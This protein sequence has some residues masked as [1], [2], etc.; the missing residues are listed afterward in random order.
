MNNR[1]IA[2]Y[3]NQNSI[4]VVSSY[5][6]EGIKYSGKV[7]AVGGYAKNTLLSLK[8]YFKENNEDRKIVVLTLKT[9]NEEMYIENGILVWRIFERNK[10]LSYSNLLKAILKFNLIKDVLVEFEFASFG[11]SQTTSLLP[12]ILLFLRG[13][14]KNT[15][16]VLHQVLS[17]LSLLTGHLGWKK[18]SIKVSIYNKILQIFLFMLILPVNKVVVL[19]ELLKKRL[20]SM[21]GFKEKIHVIP[22]GIDRGFKS[23][24]KKIARNKLNIKE[25]EFV[26]LYFGYLTW[27]KGVDF[28][29]KTLASQKGTIGG[30]K[31]RLIIAGGESVTQKTKIHYKKFVDYIYTLTNHSPEITITGFVPE[32]S[33]PLYFSA[34][35]LVVLPYRVFMSSSGPLSFAATFN[36]PF[37]ISSSL[38]GYFESSDFINCL[39]ESGLRKEDIMFAL[40]KRKF[41]EKL[42]VTMEPKRLSSL[43]T[44]SQLLAKR[45]DFRFLAPAYA[46]LFYGKRQKLLAPIF[47]PVTLLRSTV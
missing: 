18:T 39:K 36:K 5:P 21:V 37:I 9:G 31:I 30:R 6:E 19:E 7:C 15:V 45:R 35:D 23:P 13:M 20:V 2:G 40:D 44:F 33:I 46:K 10:P 41:I 24:S 16:L 26:L 14:G 12:F 42:K 47:T 29:I 17:D 28:L 1:L 34:A 4:L 22:H 3:N 32:Q 11:S 8:E 25:K 43:S 38:K 27:Y